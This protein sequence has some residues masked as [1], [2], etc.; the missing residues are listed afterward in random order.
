M[1]ARNVDNMA[2]LKN[3]WIYYLVISI[4]LLLLILG[5]KSGN[6]NS[7]H[8]V[9]G[10]FVYMIFRIFTDFYRL[11]YKNVILKKDFFK[12]II[13]FYFHFKYFK[14]LYLK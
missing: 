8:F 10:L 6:L 4:P 7:L 14:D 2:I 13:P 1:K 11:Y 9:V 3:I 5:A 12:S